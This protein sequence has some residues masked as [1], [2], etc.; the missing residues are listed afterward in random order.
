MKTVIAL[1]LTCM[2]CSSNL[3]HE[4]RSSP[5]VKK[6]KS[7]KIGGSVSQLSTLIGSTNWIKHALVQ[8]IKSQTGKWDV[9]IE[10]GYSVFRIYPY[11]RN[12]EKVSVYQGIVIKI[13][14]ANV[15]REQFIKEVI[16][17]NSNF[18]IIEYST[19]GNN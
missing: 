9:L 2:F 19:F 1:T 16:M 4:I 12:N 10:N 18:K 8:R 13:D 11:L 17:K 15:T 14:K 3:T 5:V 7:I 6:W